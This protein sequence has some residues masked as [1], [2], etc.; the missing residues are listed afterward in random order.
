MESPQQAEELAPALIRGSHLALIPSHL[1]RKRG[2]STLYDSNQLDFPIKVTGVRLEGIV[3]LYDAVL[4]FS[5][6]PAPDVLMNANIS[7]REG[8]VT[9]E[10]QTEDLF[11]SKHDASRDVDGFSL[12]QYPND[13]GG[14]SAYAEDC[15][16]LHIERIE[17]NVTS[18]KDH[19]DASNNQTFLVSVR[20]DMHGDSYGDQ[21]YE[22]LN[23]KLA[24][25]GYIIGDF[26]KSFGYEQILF[27]PQM[28]ALGVGRGS[29]SMDGTKGILEG[30]LSKS[31]LM[32]GDRFMYNSSA[33]HIED[34]K[35]DLRRQRLI[36]IK[37]PLSPSSPPK[38]IVQK[39]K[40]ESI[41]D[42]DD[43][44]SKEPA[45]AQICSIESSTQEKTW[46]KAL[47][48]G[49][50]ARIKH[51]KKK[52][53]NQ[54][55]ITNITKQLVFQSQRVLK[56]ISLGGLDPI[57]NRSR[58]QSDSQKLEVIRVRFTMN[59]LNSSS[60]MQSTGLSFQLNL[61]VDLGL[62]SSKSY[63]TGVLQSKLYDVQLSLSPRTNQNDVTVQTTSALVPVFTNGDCFTIMVS[64]VVSDFKM[65]QIETDE[66][67]DEGLQ[68]ILTAFFRNEPM[69]SHG[70]TDGTSTH[71]NSEDI[72]YQGDSMKGI[73]LGHIMVPYDT[74]IL[75][76]NSKQSLLDI[77]IPN[78]INQSNYDTEGKL[79]S[80]SSTA[81]FENREPYICT[82]DVS[83][84][85]SNDI[86][87][88]WEKIASNINRKISTENCV[89]C[90]YNQQEKTIELILFSS[91]LEQKLFLFRLVQQCLPSDTSIQKT[92]RESTTE[93]YLVRSLAAAIE[94]E[95]DS[96]NY[97]LPRDNLRAG[98]YPDI[99][100]AQI[101]TDTIYDRI[102]SLKN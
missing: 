15:K 44:K 36:D 75:R 29:E 8:N 27:L 60:F 73:V 45:T 21:N 7:G 18:H 3:N 62:N 14:D 80:R 91:S 71:E 28:S 78:D 89:R 41:Q 23:L 9:L 35:E 94:K 85:T 33:H 79:N 96:I 13:K 48:N 47:R 2:N 19:P 52:Q 51:E 87:S 95:I 16:E 32:Y 1:K 70:C 100:K 11:L 34:I 58:H 46:E 38:L 69:S 66:L 17:E 25:S 83:N 61:E 50:V 5:N 82:I 65:P 24:S 101:V 26:S 97:H 81:I 68:L 77:F 93:S 55:S 54:Q 37:A 67:V 74:M 90:Q 59:P 22:Q 72:K 12:V 102:V 53:A 57:K 20:R 6:K 31:I 86:L 39:R 10:I 63:V 84:C 43:R 40:H 49:L 30:M 98:E 76:V 99:R 56:E 64:V 92:S 4:V 88:D 42:N